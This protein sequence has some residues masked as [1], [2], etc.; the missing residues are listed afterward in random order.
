MPRHGARCF[1]LGKHAG[2]RG[3]APSANELRLWLGYRAYVSALAGRRHVVV[4]PGEPHDLVGSRWRWAS[5]AGVHAIVVARQHA[6]CDQI[7]DLDADRSWCG[8]PA[9]TGEPDVARHVCDKYRLVTTDDGH[10]IGVKVG[11]R[12]RSPQTPKFEHD[13][14]PIRISVAAKQ[15]A[16]REFLLRGPDAA[17]YEP[18]ERVDIVAESGARG[19]IV[20]VR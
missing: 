1:R 20:S 8:L 15:Y 18:V 7:G 9:P 6:V 19:L 12:C 17:L 16:Q 5:C 2:Q 14:R 13:L 11:R 10:A 3:F 4:D